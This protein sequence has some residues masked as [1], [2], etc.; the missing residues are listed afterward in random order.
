M[1]PENLY[2]GKTR[3]WPRLNEIWSIAVWKP[4]R[5]SQ[6]CSDSYSAITTVSVET[7]RVR[8]PLHSGH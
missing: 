5:Y 8:I 6:S 7:L 3:A 1:L 2:C 4:E